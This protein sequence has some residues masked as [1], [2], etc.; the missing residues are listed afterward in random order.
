MEITRADN[1]KNK[2]KVMTLRG[3]FKQDE[4][5][6]SILESAGMA[7][8]RSGVIQADRVRRSLQACNY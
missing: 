1:L 7:L 6:I 2:S 8:A 4:T 5:V 3:I